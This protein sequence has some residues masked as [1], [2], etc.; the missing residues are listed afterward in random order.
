VTKSILPGLVLHA[1]GDVFSMTRQWTAG[2][3]EWQLP[4]TSSPRLIWDT[5]IDPAFIRPV[6]VFGVFAILMTLVY[7]VL[8]RVMRTE[9]S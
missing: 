8:A 9:S 5:G 2:K 6:I 1:A 4:T 3:S 7:V